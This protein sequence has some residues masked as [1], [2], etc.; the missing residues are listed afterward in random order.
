MS[1]KINS[2]EIVHPRDVPSATTSAKPRSSSAN[3][4][5]IIR[6]ALATIIVAI[7]SAF[8]ICVF[9]STDPEIKQF[10]QAAF[11][12]LTGFGSGAIGFAFGVF[13]SKSVSE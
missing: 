1:E 2:Q 12:V 7:V 3:T 8:C 10:K 6:L 11:T 4:N 13:T 5:E 9:F